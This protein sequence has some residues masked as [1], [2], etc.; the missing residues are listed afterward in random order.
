M[1]KVLKLSGA[2]GSILWQYVLGS[3][4]GSQSRP[5]Q[6]LAVNHLGDVV[7]A[8]RAGS[9]FTVA[10]LSGSDGTE[11]WRRVVGT[12]TTIGEAT[13]VAF[14][15]SGDVWVGGAN[16]RTATS[17]MAVLTVAKLSGATGDPLWLQ[18]VGGA[19]D[20]TLNG[21]RAEA[22][23][24]DGAGTA[25]AAGVLESVGRGADFAIVKASEGISGSR[26]RMVDPAG[27]PQHR[28]F[29][30]QSKDTS[31]LTAAAQ[32]TADPTVVGGSL[33]V[34]NLAPG[35]ED[36][37]ALPAANWTADP[38]HLRYAYGDAQR[39]A[40]PCDAVSIRMGR[41]LKAVCQ[42]SQIHFSLDEP[43][44]G[45]LAV[46]LIVGSTFHACMSFGGTVR[47][48][49]PGRFEAI[50]APAPIGCPGLS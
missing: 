41:G 46:T 28:R 12:P 38:V 10:M 44:Q 11:R 34:H 19:G 9:D 43:R 5:G 26:V 48:D 2:D 33:Q 35:E 15:S 29:L 18:F 23:A 4:V 32:T 39:S 21:G 47:N 1:V 40:G 6:A 3:G 42:G 50:N 20:P 16:Q 31:V 25:F 7:V 37:F 24:V 14:D 45:A 13:G 17:A 30:V 22:I 8:G 27:D 36:T 49:L